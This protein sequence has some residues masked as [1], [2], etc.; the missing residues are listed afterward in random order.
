VKQLVLCV[1]L[2]V[3]AC[4][5]ATSPSPASTGEAVEPP[6][7]PSLEIVYEKF[8]EIVVNGEV[9]D[10]DIVVEDGKVRK[11]DKGPSRPQRAKYGH[12]PLTP[13]ESIPWDCKT[14]VVG[15]GMHGRLP[16]VPELNEEARRRNVEVIALKTPEAVRYFLKHLGLD[17]NAIFHITC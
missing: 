3:A 16:V 12:T 14:L 2:A 8:G 11:R 9:L 4:A 5:P 6:A 7:A 15:T 13:L 1:L 17:V 10:H